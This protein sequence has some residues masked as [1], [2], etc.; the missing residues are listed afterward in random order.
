MHE[1]L[2]ARFVLVD[3]VEW[4]QFIPTAGGCESVNL[5][6]HYVSSLKEA[7]AHAEH[8]RRTLNITS[9]PFQ[10]WRYPVSIP[11]PPIIW[12]LILISW[13]IILQDLHELLQDIRYS[14]TPSTSYK[15]WCR[16]QAA[17][18]AKNLSPE[19]AFP[20]RLRPRAV[21]EDFWAVS[22][23]PNR[24]KDT[25]KKHIDID[26]RGNWITPWKMQ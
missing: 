5:A 6:C 19:V 12:W 9:G 20:S 25:I 16:G 17:Y 14:P 10:H 21:T 26:F 2:S 8:S 23:R 22:D 18:A 15:T 13:R 11:H 3:G 1:M 7:K 24:P 4:R